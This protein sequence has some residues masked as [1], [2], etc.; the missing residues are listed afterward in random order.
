MDI[1]AEDVYLYKLEAIRK[2]ETFLNAITGEVGPKDINLALK[3]S[4]EVLTSLKYVFSNPNHPNYKK[5]V[6]LYLTASTTEE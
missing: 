3:N 6:E 5:G 1:Y 4:Y 2:D